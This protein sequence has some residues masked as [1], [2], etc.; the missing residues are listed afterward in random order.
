MFGRGIDSNDALYRRNTST[1]VEK[2]NP[3]LYLKLR[4]RGSLDMIVVC[5][6]QLTQ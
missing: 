3:L 4:V 5:E 1:D 2:T 6:V